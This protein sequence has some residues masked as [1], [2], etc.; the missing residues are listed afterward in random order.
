M[1]QLGG[2]QFEFSEFFVQQ[3][4]KGGEYLQRGCSGA[5]SRNID[6]TFDG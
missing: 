5:E 4:R 3:E 1:M 2:F 6:A